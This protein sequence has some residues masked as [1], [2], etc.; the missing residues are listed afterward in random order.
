[1][2]EFVAN[3]PILA[4]MLGKMVYPFMFFFTFIMCLSYESFQNVI[5]GHPIVSFLVLEC[6]AMV[7]THLISL[8]TFIG[9]AFS[10]LCCMFILSGVFTLILDSLEPDSLQY[11][12][13]L[14]VIFSAISLP[15]SFINLIF[16][17]G[18]WSIPGLSYIV[19]GI[20]NALTS[21]IY[22]LA[23]RSAWEVYCTTKGDLPIVEDKI[24]SNSFLGDIFGGVP[25][26]FASAPGAVVFYI[27]FAMICL[28]TFVATIICREKI[29]QLSK[30]F[31]RGIL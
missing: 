27:V 26:G 23:I 7:L 21:A 20:L 8:F 16:D 25:G 19:A 17:G 24:L 1:M 4:L 9:A 29:K 3:H 28:G 2:G 15:L 6:G 10:A 30:E 13:L 11:C 22:I 31:A 12:I 5:P 18:R 14:I